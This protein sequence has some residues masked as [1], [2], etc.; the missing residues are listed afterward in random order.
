MIKRK[1]NPELFLNSDEAK[2]VES[3]IGES[4][5]QTSAEIK[6]IILR[7]CWDKL[8]HKA[9]SLFRKYGLHATQYRNAV[10]ILLVTAN[11]EFLIYGDQGIHE[12]VGQNFWDDTRNRMTD[13]FQNDQFG[14]GLCEGIKSIGDKLAAYFPADKDN[15]NELSDEII[16]E[17]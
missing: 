11:R 8:E 12:K 17:K 3:A 2:Q 14:S 4:E 7:H 5:K 6:L 13:F 10:L 9:E 1:H 15:P 16:H